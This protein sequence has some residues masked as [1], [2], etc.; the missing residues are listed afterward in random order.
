MAVAAVVVLSLFVFDPFGGD[1]AGTDGLLVDDDG[2]PFIAV[3]EHR[4]APSREVEEP[5]E[6]LDM[7]VEPEAMVNPTAEG[8]VDAQTD[9]RG[10]RT[11]ADG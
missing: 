4:R 9:S 6:V 11:S 7:V 5:A 2:A 8:D 10:Q 3:I 1:E